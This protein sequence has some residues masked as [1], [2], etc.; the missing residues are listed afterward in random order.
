MRAPGLP[1][2]PGTDTAAQGCGGGRGRRHCGSRRRRSCA[3]AAKAPAALHALAATRR[4]VVSHAFEGCVGA[5]GGGRRCGLRR[6]RHRWRRRRRRRRRRASPATQTCSSARP[7][8]ARPATAATTAVE[9]APATPAAVGPSTVPAAVAARRAAR[10][11]CGCPL[12]PLA[13]APPT[14]GGGARPRPPALTYSALQHPRGAELF[15]PQAPACG[16]GGG[17]GGGGG[18]S[19]T[20][21]PD[22]TGGAPARLV[23]DGLPMDGA[24]PV[25]SSRA[26]PPSRLHA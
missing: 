26:P 12:P 14:A 17:G 1:L 18:G 19:L 24:Q 22:V 11:C 15:T 9:T 21:P 8:P 7:R 23:S 25:W 10:R 16:S 3:A 20:P 2:Q 5:G 6:R 13:T 4:A